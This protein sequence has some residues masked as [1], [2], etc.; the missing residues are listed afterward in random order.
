MKKLIILVCLV[1]SGVSLSAQQVKDVVYLNNGNIVKGEIVSSTDTEIEIHATNGELYTFRKIEI[2]RIDSG[3]QL[4]A[5]PDA[6]KKSNFVR[7]GEREKGYWASVD[8]GLG[9]ALDRY[10][11]NNTSPA[12]PIDLNVAMGY[13]F[14]EFIMVGLGAGVRYYAHQ[15]DL[16]YHNQEKN[17]DYAWS[18]PLYAQLRGAFISGHTRSMVP[19]WQ[20]SAGYTVNDGVMIQ[21]ALGLRF[22]AATRHHFTLSL[23]YTAQQGYKYCEESLAGKKFLNLVQIRLGYQF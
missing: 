13:R 5:I 17:R 11:K 8:L 23:S 16:R 12:I 20:L 22:G 21:P 2:R 18:F 19:Y 15:D 3:E 9:V 7:Y 1:F 10:A 6:P 14:N 4:D